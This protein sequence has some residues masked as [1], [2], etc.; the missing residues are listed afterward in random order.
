MIYYTSLNRWYDII[1]SCHEYNSVISSLHRSG[2]PASSPSC[3]Q[4][5]FNIARE[6][7]EGLVSEVSWPMSRQCSATYGIQS[8]GRFETRAVLGYPFTP[9]IYFIPLW[10]LQWSHFDTLYTIKALPFTRCEWQYSESSW[11]FASLHLIFALWRP[12]LQMIQVMR[13]LIAGPTTFLMQCWNA[14][15]GLET[16][17]CQYSRNEDSTGPQGLVYR[18]ETS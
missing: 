10:S 1:N 6:K 11:P 5:F 18:V 14:E 13:L 15:S 12:F 3:S 16:R 8:N 2:S 7:R 4:L 9:G 17:L